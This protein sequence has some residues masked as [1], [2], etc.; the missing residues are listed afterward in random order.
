MRLL[1][2]CDP[3]F[4]YTCKLNRSAA[5]G[6]TLTL[7]KV[8]DDIKRLFDDMDANAVKEPDLYA[9]YQ[10]VRLP[11]LFFTDFMIRESTLNIRSDWVPMAYEENELAG[12]EKFFDLLEADLADPTDGALERLLVYFTC[13]GLGFSGVYFDQPENIQQLMARIAVRISRFMD[14]DQ[15]SGLCPQA[16][17]YTDTR[18]LTQSTGTKVVGIGI[19]LI[20][21]IIVLIVTYFGL[22]SWAT[23][24]MRETI[25]EIGGAATVSS[26]KI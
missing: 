21:L 7:E 12:D 10:G 24:E 6:C 8:V 11:L 19:V 4:Q 26:E 25:S 22:F 16:Y 1:K 13:L 9:E 18:D 5:K 14:A 15:R 20:A 2:L 23:L 17:D 3:L